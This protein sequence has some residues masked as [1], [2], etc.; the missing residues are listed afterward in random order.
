[1]LQAIKKLPLTLNVNQAI[2][3][4]HKSIIVTTS[5]FLISST[6][7]SPPHLTKTNIALRGF[8]TP[9]PADFVSAEYLVESGQLSLFA[10]GRARRFT[11]GITFVRLPWLGALKFVIEGWTGPLAGP[12]P[13][14]D[15]YEI[16]DRLSIQLPNR[17]L[18]GDVLLVVTA[19]FP[20]GIEVPIFFTGVRLPPTDPS[21]DPNSKGVTVGGTQK[22]QVQQVEPQQATTQLQEVVSGDENMHVFLNSEFS[23]KHSDHVPGNRGSV[24]IKYDPL[25]LSLVTARIVDTDIVWIFKAIKDG[26]TQ[27]R[28]SGVDLLIWWQTINVT[29]LQNNIPVIHPG[30]TSNSATTSNGA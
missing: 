14:F 3:Q 17:A 20:N 30:E 22:P 27:V 5:G 1:V 12:E 6:H 4:Q 29:I 7:S 26:T 2:F 21:A 24:D 8:L 15:H 13:Q 9:Q 11:T 19:D 18:P 23:I 10:R 28:V 25:Y 16:T